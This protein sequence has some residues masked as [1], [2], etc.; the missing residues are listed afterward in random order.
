[1]T[2]IFV[3]GSTGYIGKNVVKYAL[4][5]GFDVVTAKRHSDNKPGQLNKKLK[6]IKISNNDNN[7]IADLEKVDVIISCLASRTGE[8]K[9]AHLVDYKLNCLL[10]EKAKA[11]KCSQFILLSAI[12][13]QKPRLAFQ[14]EKLAFEEEL[15]KSGLNFSI[16]RPTA[17]FKSLSG[18]IENIKKGKPYVYFGDGQITQ[19]NPISEKDLSLYIL[20]CI[21]DKTKWRK[22][23][24]IGGPKQSI[25]PKDIGKILFEIF[26]VS[27]KYKSFPTKL[28][29]AI[30][31]LLL[32]ISPFSNW[33]K[34]KSELIKIA[35]YYATESMLIWDEKK[36]CYDANMTPS[37]GKDTLR[38]YFYSIKNLD[39]Q[40]E[41]DRD[42]KLLIFD[43]EKSKRLWG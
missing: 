33:A 27:P 39:L 5:N 23:L 15:K 40:L 6:V 41:I 22:I 21:K 35:K 10:L 38:D 24:P 34:N 31:L 26:E 9:D 16:V 32:I 11:L 18:Q 37:T 36:E 13:V 30:R 29:D 19:C 17:Y 7:W 8:P 28:L 3:A 2:K 25:T 43:L 4:D 42:S 12:C 1:L 14:F 20:S